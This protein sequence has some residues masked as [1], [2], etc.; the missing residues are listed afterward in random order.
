MKKHFYKLAIAALGLFGAFSSNGQTPCDSSTFSQNLG[1][2]G[3]EPEFIKCNA[4]D[5]YSLQ[6]HSYAKSDLYFMWATQDNK[7]LQQGTLFED[8][9]TGEFKLMIEG[10]GCLKEIP[11]TIFD[12]PELLIWADKMS[13]CANE[14]KPTLQTN[15]YFFGA[16]PSQPTSTTILKNGNYFEYVPFGSTTISDV[17]AG[18][19]EL[20]LDDQFCWNPTPNNSLT[21]VEEQ[22]VP[23]N[24]TPDSLEVYGEM[25]G[26][27]YE[28]CYESSAILHFPEG[29]TTDNLTI[30][31]TKNGDSYKTDKT[32]IALYQ[33]NEFDNYQINV[34]GNGCTWQETFSTH[35][36]SIS[37]VFTSND[38]NYRTCTETPLVLTAEGNP[39]I[40]G[41]IYEWQKQV[42]VGKYEKVANGSTLTTTEEGKYRLFVYT[43]NC[44]NYSSIFTVST[45]ECS[46]TCPE[47]WV[48]KRFSQYPHFPSSPI[49]QNYISIC[50]QQSVILE[51][52]PTKGTGIIT[53]Y[54]YNSG[55]EVNMEGN[56][57]HLSSWGKY[58]AKY[59][60][61][62]CSVVSDT[63]W[64]EPS[65]PTELTIIANVDGAEVPTT[66][67][68]ITICPSN[69]IDLTADPIYHTYYE[70]SKDGTVLT[71]ENDATLYNVD[72]G[73]Y[74]LIVEDY[75]GCLAD[76]AIT[77]IENDSPN[78]TVSG[79]N[80]EFGTT[81]EL[82]PNPTSSSLTL[83]GGND[84]NTVQIVSQ[85]GQTNTV[86]VTNG[87]IN[88]SSYQAGIYTLLIERNG[89]IE[90][91]K[92]VKQ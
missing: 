40:T 8:D 44:G 15:I 49:L 75:K 83:V 27:Y 20:R 11:F 82:A 46:T 7:I 9:T 52:Y 5:N 66:N 1:L 41:E 58:L 81:I 24:C 3:Y 14:T 69:T 53:W 91:H 74:N 12:T 57:L 60:D 62:H 22:C 36:D 63:I 28:I 55:T 25:T 2:S 67:D 88:L 19:Y 71:G 13:Y 86:N 26:D 32:G 79:I 6:A 38:P 37:T 89:T 72:P 33:E 18:T 10:M 59:E 51:A 35:T 54:S 42:S 65:I 21:I 16:Q 85:L 84:I 76:A 80:D 64:V 56:P 61:E 77:V 31:W 45:K 34:T 68:K 48:E 39:H 30:E 29:Q 4:W 87:T 23:D 92:I 50:D 47:I 17:E 73:Y 78:C 70:W 90:T 43:N